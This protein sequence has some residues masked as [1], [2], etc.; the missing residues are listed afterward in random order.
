MPRPSKAVLAAPRTFARLSAA[1]PDAHC[2]LEHRNPFQLIVAT[3]LSAQATDVIV[4]RVTPDLFARYPDAPALAGADPAAVEKII[5]RLGMF[6]QKTKNIVGLAKKL[7]AE[8][9][10]EVPRSLAELVELPGVGRKTANVVLG[11]AFQAPEGVVVDTHVQRITQR[12]GWT[13][14]TTPEK[15][16]QDLMKIFPRR[17]WDPLSHV[18]IFHGRRICFAQ[19]PACAT[20][21]VNDVCPS[22]FRAELIGRKPGRS[23]RPVTSLPSGRA[24]APKPRR[25]IAKRPDRRPPP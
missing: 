13:K 5:G 19:K 21:P 12:L 14:E 17:N 18:L 16:E 7:V 24:S 1:H 10:G 4:N 25:S 11:V 9:G 15:I 20:C 3:V 8:H 6:R 2:E 22:A 23:P